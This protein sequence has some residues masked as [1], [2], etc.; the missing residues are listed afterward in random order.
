MTSITTRLIATS[1]HSVNMNAITTA[2]SVPTPIAITMRLIEFSESVGSRS[3]ERRLRQ[4]CDQQIERLCVPR[5]CLDA[6]NSVPERFV[7]FKQVSDGNPHLIV[8]PIREILFPPPIS[9]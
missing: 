5:K 7:T 2:P 1:N 9:E 4:L 3:L 6:W 8:K